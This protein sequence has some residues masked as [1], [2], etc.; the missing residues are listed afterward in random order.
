MSGFKMYRGNK[1]DLRKCEL[2]KISRK[3]NE[4]LTVVHVLG[5]WKKPD[6]WWW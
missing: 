2:I 5:G 4:D 3:N 6:W 1:T